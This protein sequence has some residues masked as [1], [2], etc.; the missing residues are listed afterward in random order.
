[1]NKQFDL[2]N[3]LTILSGQV[4][5]AYDVADLVRQN[6]QGDLK[7]DAEAIFERISWAAAL[8][9]TIRP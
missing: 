5:A 4:L 9:E 6:A 3:L 2:G 1:M 7:R 8:L